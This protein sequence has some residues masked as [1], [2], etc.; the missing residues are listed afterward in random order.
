MRGQ[1]DAGLGKRC[2]LGSRRRRWRCRVDDTGFVANAGMRFKVQPKIELE[3]DL[4]YT[5]NDLL[6]DDGIGI[7]AAAR[8][9][10]NDQFSIAP[11]L[12]MDTEFDGLFVGVRYD[13]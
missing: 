9:Y 1:R 8:F 3:G 12:A 4:K 7:Q 11:G 6:V 13:L 10:L 5:S 2:A